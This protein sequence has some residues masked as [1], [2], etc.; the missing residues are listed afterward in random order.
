MNFRWPAWL[1]SFFLTMGAAAHATDAEDLLRIQLAAG[2]ARGMPSISIAIATRQGVIWSDAVGYANL[3]MEGVAARAGTS[4]PVLYRRWHNRAELMLAA[5]RRSLGSVSKEIP[6]TGSLRGDV[7]SVLRRLRDRYREVGP[8]V[9]HGVMLELHDL[10]AS[11]FQILPNA[12]MT[13][14]KRAAARGEARIEGVTPRMAGL[15]GDMLRHELMLRRANVSDAVLEE[16]VDDLF[17]PLV[18]PSSPSPPR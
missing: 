11:Q 9:V 1:L 5:V 18:R 12:M 8:D 3:T 13:I 14:L 15:P 7:L 17:L 2:L 10:P 16:I 6:D 4:K